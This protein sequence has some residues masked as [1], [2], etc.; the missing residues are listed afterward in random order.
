[1]RGV[2]SAEVRIEEVQAGV[3]DVPACVEIVLE[4][5]SVVG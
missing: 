1:M 5:E 3:V 2:V 4:L